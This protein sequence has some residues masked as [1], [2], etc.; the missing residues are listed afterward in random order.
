MRLPGSSY[1]AAIDNQCRHMPV[2]DGHRK[3]YLAEVKRILKSGGQ[4]FF[5]EKENNASLPPVL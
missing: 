3:K 4:A 1:N 5:R 2:T